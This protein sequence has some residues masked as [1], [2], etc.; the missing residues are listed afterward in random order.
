MKKNILYS[1]LGLV[2]TCTIAHQ[3]SAQYI[4]GPSYYITSY[5]FS[6][7]GAPSGPGGL[8]EASAVKPMSSYG[9]Y[10]NSTLGQ[11]SPLMDSSTPPVSAGFHLY[12]GFWYTIQ[13]GGTEPTLI[14]LSSF[15][16]TPKDRAVVVRW[17]T[18]S[19]VDNAGFNL[20]RAESEDGSYVKINTILIAA[21]G[22]AT[23]GTTYELID[24]SV[25]NRKAYYYK[26]EDIDLSGKSTLHGAVSTMP[27]WVYGGIK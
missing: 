6:N 9:F 11:P 20:Y 17:A 18:A 24:K 2:L 7:G 5:V 13:T 19:E 14:V 4:K 12:Y 21:K 10:M 1:A 22:T 27:R 25:E 3:A 15:T 26:L 23:R 16:V 8:I